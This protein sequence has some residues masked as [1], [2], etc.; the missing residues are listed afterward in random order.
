MIHQINAQN[1]MKEL[2]LQFV[3]VSR[4]LLVDV[5]DASFLTQFLGHRGQIRRVRPQDALQ[6]L[7]VLLAKGPSTLLSVA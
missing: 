2:G 3:P 5:G 1:I 7:E 6:S 4:Q